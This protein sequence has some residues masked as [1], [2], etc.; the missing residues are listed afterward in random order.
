MLAPP[1]A[2]RAHRCDPEFENLESVDDDTIPVGTYSPL[3][4][5]LRSFGMIVLIPLSLSLSLLCSH[6]REERACDSGRQIDFQ[7]RD[8][9]H[10][11]LVLD[12]SLV[13][14]QMPC[15]VLFMYSRCC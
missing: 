15:R 13:V 14:Y 5:T 8:N 4:S 7:S 12:E 6:S 11:V 9:V 10:V 3:I 1:S 2:L